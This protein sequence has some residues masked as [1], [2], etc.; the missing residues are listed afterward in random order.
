MAKQNTVVSSGTLTYAVKCRL[1]AD[2][3]IVVEGRLWAPVAEIPS[4]LGN[5]GY[6]PFSVTQLR[7]RNGSSCPL[8]DLRADRF[9]RLSRVEIRASFRRPEAA[10]RATA[11]EPSGYGPFPTHGQA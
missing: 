6:P 4:P 11:G 8:S 1:S 2:L 10:I 7:I 3:F 5:A 9:E